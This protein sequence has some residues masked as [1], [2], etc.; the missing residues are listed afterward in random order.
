MLKEL[1]YD[2]ISQIFR[3]GKDLARRIAAYDEVGLHVLS[4]YLN[5]DDRSIAPEVVRPL[6]NR[7]RIELTIRRTTPKTV[8]A[9]RQTA[10]MAA[11]NQTWFL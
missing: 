11:N 4:I 5:V 6:K 8:Q 3:G 1:G 7:G 2:G 9:V 10:E